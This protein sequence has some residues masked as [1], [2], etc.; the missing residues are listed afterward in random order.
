MNRRR[1]DLAIVRALRKGDAAGFE[2]FFDDVFS[3][4]Y[5]NVLSET[6][7]EVTAREITQRALVIGIERLDDFRGS[8]SLF[9]WLRGIAHDVSREYSTPVVRRSSRSRFQELLRNLG[10]PGKPGRLLHD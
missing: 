7:D 9:E 3:P 6:G 1:Q 8:Q 2:R 5:Q 10:G 4:L